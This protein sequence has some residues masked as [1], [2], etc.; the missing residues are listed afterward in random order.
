[1]AV[2]LQRFFL[3]FAAICILPG[4]LSAAQATPQSMTGAYESGLL[5]GQGRATLT[6][7][8][9]GNGIVGQLTDEKGKIFALRG[10]GSDKVVQGK[11]FHLNRSVNFVAEKVGASV[12][13]S[14]TSLDSRAVHRSILLKK[15]ASTQSN[16]A[17]DRHAADAFD[18]FLS[19]YQEW[20]DRVA[21]QSFSELA[22]GH[23][24]LVQLFG[25]LHADIFVRVCRSRSHQDLQ[26]EL[27]WSQSLSCETLLKRA[28]FSKNE[29]ELADLAARAKQQA[30]SLSKAVDCTVRGRANAVG[31]S[32]EQTGIRFSPVASAWRDAAL[33]LPERAI[34]APRIAVAAKLLPGHI[35]RLKPVQTGLQVRPTKFAVPVLKPMSDVAMVSAAPKLKGV[36]SLPF[37]RL[38]VNWHTE[39]QAT[40]HEWS[41]AYADET[42]IDVDDAVGTVGAMPATS[43]LP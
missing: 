9:V 38:D 22:P 4:M 39:A 43:T 18:L 31:H 27:G 42:F 13:L 6:F 7:E 8:K 36:V 21:A 24:S 23:R 11:I 37:E 12:F 17:P 10:K 34:E 30:L 14:F 35:V 5:G 1:M 28:A 40:L 19:Q 26:R 25:Y 15:K 2:R 16:G 29:D 32:C 33:L 41:L 20:D 3:L